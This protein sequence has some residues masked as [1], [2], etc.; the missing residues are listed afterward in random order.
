[1]KNSCWGRLVR[2]TSSPSVATLAD[3]LEVRRTL[4]PSRNNAWAIVLQLGWYSLDC[5]NRQRTAPDQVLAWG[6]LNYENCDHEFLGQVRLETDVFAWCASRRE[7]AHERP[8]QCH[9]CVETLAVRERESIREFSNPFDTI[10]ICSGI[11]IQC[12]GSRSNG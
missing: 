4:N 1:M 8:D 9:L 5:T 12:S 10:G 11:D 3:G 6:T 2:W 7:P